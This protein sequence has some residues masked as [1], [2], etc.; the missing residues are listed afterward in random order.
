MAKN[1]VATD[2]SLEYYLNGVLQKTFPRGEIKT[3]VTST[4]VKVIIV[5]TGDHFNLREGDSING[6]EQDSKQEIAKLVGAFSLGG[7]DGNGVI[8]W[9]T[10]DGK[11][12]VIASGSTAQEAR[13][14][15]GAISEDNLPTAQELIPSG[16]TNGQV[17]KKNASGQNVWAADTN[18]TYSTATESTNGLMSST[19]KGKL[20]NIAENANNFSL[21]S[22]TNGQVLK[23][24][25]TNWAAGTDNNTT[26]S[27]ATASANG[28]IPSFP[29]TGTHVLKAIDGVL[30]WV[31]E[32]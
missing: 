29:S 28:L 31:E 18:T 27:V 17:L 10:L 16:G 15:I 9:E 13:E 20:N 32:A 24:N 14:A 25:G 2:T 26:Y 4:L 12:E 30:S 6:E 7:D 1:L 21:P 5:Q 11:P 19:D 8:D 3:E 23:H 22:G